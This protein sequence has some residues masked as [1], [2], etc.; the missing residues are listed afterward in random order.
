MLGDNWILPTTDWGFEGEATIE[1]VV[2]SKSHKRHCPELLSKSNVRQSI[3]WLHSRAQYRSVCTVNVSKG[4]KELSK[5][6]NSWPKS[7]MLTIDW[8]CLLG[9]TK[10]NNPARRHSSICWTVLVM[11]H[12]KI[13]EE[14]RMLFQFVIEM[15]LLYSEEQ[16]IFYK[17][18]F[19]ISNWHST[20]GFIA[21]S[22]DFSSMTFTEFIYS[23]RKL[24]FLNTE[25][26]K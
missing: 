10:I 1:P 4:G 16:K 14:K 20:H 12:S 23:S 6:T 2:M 3:R 26:A 19:L 18:A 8:S 24:Y 22:Y 21:T 15:Y 13:R 7:L 25:F 17:K 11:A 9:W 5:G